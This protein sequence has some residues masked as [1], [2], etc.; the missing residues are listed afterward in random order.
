M[1][2]ND[3]GNEQIQVIISKLF[4]FVGLKPIYSFNSLIEVDQK[5]LSIRADYVVTTREPFVIEVFECFFDIVRKMYRENI[6]FQTASNSSDYNLLFYDKL[7]PPF[8]VG[9]SILHAIMGFNPTTKHS[10]LEHTSNLP[11]NL[12]YLY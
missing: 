8:R 11:V 4:S 5:V 10:K 6:T 9:G 7:T 12:S 3:S 2:N 1:M